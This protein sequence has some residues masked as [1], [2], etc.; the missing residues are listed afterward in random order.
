MSRHNAWWE[1]LNKN[2]VWTIRAQQSF[3]DQLQRQIPSMNELKDRRNECPRGDFSSVTGSFLSFNVSIRCRHF[4]P[5]TTKCRLYR[6]RVLCLYPFLRYIICTTIANEPYNRIST[7]LPTRPFTQAKLSPFFY[8][9]ITISSPSYVHLFICTCLYVYLFSWSK[10]I[11]WC[12]FTIL[13]FI[14]LNI[15][16]LPTFFPRTDEGSAT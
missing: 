11:K 16:C 15:I 5:P 12:P 14:L 1:Q 3:K 13:D 9:R 4:L 8:L 6:P 2:C 10:D 7:S